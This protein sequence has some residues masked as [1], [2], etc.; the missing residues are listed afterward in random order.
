MKWQNGGILSKIDKFF[1]DP[2]PENYI[3]ALDLISVDEHYEP[4][5]MHIEKI[6]ELLDNNEFQAVLDGI[7]EALPTLILSPIAHHLAHLAAEKIDDTE[8]T[9]MEDFMTQACLVCALRTGDGTRDKPFH[10]SL[11]QDEYALMAALKRSTVK[12]ELVQDGTRWLDV[13]KGE[14]DVETVFDIT[15]PYNRLTKKFGKNSEGNQ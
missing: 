3:T 7:V 10:V 2:T 13:L 11:P 14:D 5:A 1:Q 8:R 6:E 15:R 4:Y 12:Q 9:K